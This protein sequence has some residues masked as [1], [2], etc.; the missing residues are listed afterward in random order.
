LPLAEDLSRRDFTIN[1]IAVNVVTNEITDPYNGVA[2]L[3]A[4]LLRAVGDPVVRFAEDHSRLLRALRFAVT[5]DLTI[6]PGTSTVLFEQLRNTLPNALGSSLPY[7][8]ASREFVRSLVADP[9]RT[10]QLWEQ[11]GALD[12][13]IPEFAP[14]RTCI[15]GPYHHSEGDVWT[16]TQMVMGVLASEAHHQR[17]GI[18][19]PT[20]LCAALCHDIGKPA[21][22]NIRQTES[23]EDID[24]YG[25]SEAG[26]QIWSAVA[27]RLRL[28]AVG[29]D[30]DLVSFLISHHMVITLSDLELMSPTEF[31]DLFL[32]RK[33]EFLE[34]LYVADMR[35]RISQV[36]DLEERIEAKLK[37]IAGLRGVY[38][39]RGADEPALLDG[40]RL[41]EIARLS[42]GPQVGVALTRLRDLQLQG[43][44]STAA[45]AEQ[46]VRDHL[47]QFTS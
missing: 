33:G 25:H 32:D 4:R 15:Q 47:D 9:V 26:A 29:V 10:L 45:E 28:A 31:C 23:G 24:F 13:L 19:G 44:L 11:A 40:A 42:A 30:V 7:E 38:I 36:P 46:Y 17:F 43:S 14:L 18:P 35:G 39:A 20:L 3:A 27:K 34:S 1:A 12:I 5:C 6:D 8:L 2:D 41:M 21:A 16:H 22:R 37:Q